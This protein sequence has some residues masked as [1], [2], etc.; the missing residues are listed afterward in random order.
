MLRGTP[1]QGAGVGQPHDAACQCV[2]NRWL[3]EQH[4]RG[5][6]VNSVPLVAAAEVV[7]D[8]AVN[9][10][11]A[12]AKKLFNREI[13]LRIR[14]LDNEVKAAI[15]LADWNNI[16]RLNDRVK[17]AFYDINKRGDMAKTYLMPEY[18]EAKLRELNLTFEIAQ[19]KALKKEEDREQ[20]RFEREAEK[21]E[22]KEEPVQV[23]GT[24]PP[25]PPVRVPSAT[26]LLRCYRSA[27]PRL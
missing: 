8:V 17:C 9:G 13:K 26:P 22:Q 21:E 20:R 1:E 4:A 12:G 5:S 3:H 6:Q 2:P 25:T 16:G 27:P 15:A 10:R 23:A 19:L 24:V 14:C 18:L 11:K 7:D